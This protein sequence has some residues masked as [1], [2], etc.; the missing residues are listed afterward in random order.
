[1]GLTVKDSVNEKRENGIP[2]IKRI[3][4]VIL[5]QFWPFPILYIKKATTAKE[6]KA[7]KMTNPAPKPTVFAAFNE[8]ENPTMLWRSPKAIVIQSIVTAVETLFG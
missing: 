2:M 7:T 3:K 4:N 6:K 8:S 1:M 5:A